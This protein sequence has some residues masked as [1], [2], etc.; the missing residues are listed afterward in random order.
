MKVSVLDPGAEVPDA[1][2]E[3]ERL[4]KGG[5][6]GQAVEWAKEAWAARRRNREEAGYVPLRD[7]GE[8]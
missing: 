6:M 4:S 2:Q 8:V 3:A 5:F 7:M 1:E